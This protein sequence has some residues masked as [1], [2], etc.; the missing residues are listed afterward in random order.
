MAAARTAAGP[1]VTACARQTAALFSHSAPHGVS[2]EALPRLQ[3]GAA[4]G[5]AADISSKRRASARTLAAA[6]CP[7]AVERRGFYSPAHAFSDCTPCLLFH[8]A[9]RRAQHRRR[10]STNR[11]ARPYLPIRNRRRARLPVRAARRS[12]PAALLTPCQG[13]LRQYLYSPI[14]PGQFLFWSLP[15]RS[16]HPR[17][18]VEQIYK[19]EYT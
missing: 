15:Y 13:R 17:I 5:N 9:A 1:A 7:A 14:L 3:A 12:F 6:G 19:Q 11:R 2:R 8:R 18:P 10:F 16:A 4:R